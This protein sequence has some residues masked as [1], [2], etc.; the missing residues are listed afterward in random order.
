[1]SKGR[2]QIPASVLEDNECDPSYNPSGTYG[3]GRK[4]DCIRYMLICIYIYVIDQPSA[5]KVL[6]MY[7][8]TVVAISRHVPD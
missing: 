7:L 1:M 4:L 8:A 3:V 2:V 5:A 6:T